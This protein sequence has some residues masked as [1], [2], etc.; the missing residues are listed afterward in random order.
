MDPKIQAVIDE[1]Q[2]RADAETAE[3]QN[4]NRRRDD[5]LLPI[6]KAT[7]TLVS[8][9][10]KEMKAQS[11]L[12]IGTSYG[13]ST[14]WLADAARA[15]G[16]RVTTLELH[17]HKAEYA[18]ERIERAGLS[19]HV[20]FKIGDAL[21]TIRT[22]PGP[23]DFVLLDLWKNLY[24]P[25]FDIFYPKLA[26][27]ALVVADNMLFPDTARPDAEAYRAHV[28]RAADV[29]TVLLPVGSGIELTRYR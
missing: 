20:E 17:A 18:R 11:I 22:L 2:A 25:C 8:L 16:G 13:Y 6:G 5:L 19:A 24:V 9:L 14:V 1:Y 21:E 26:A 4:P 3:M 15:T 28:R 27:G 7:A 10:I 29:T 12:E 23:F